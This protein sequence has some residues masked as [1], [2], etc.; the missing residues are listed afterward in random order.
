MVTAPKLAKDLNN[1]SLEELVNS[2]RSHEI[3]LDQDKPQKRGKSIALK[4]IRRS[5]ESKALQAED[6]E[7]SEEDSDEE[8]DEL[9]LLS[10]R[11][12]CL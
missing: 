10:K 3:E 5:K 2:L 7:D 9:S 11:L 6:I 4:T 12:N 8:D 1:I